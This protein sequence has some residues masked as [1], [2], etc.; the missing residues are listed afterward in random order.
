MPLTDTAIKNAKPTEKP[1]KIS[2]GGG[3][4]IQIQPTGSKLW[5]LKYRFGGVE[6][7]IGLGMYPVISL[8]RAREL[9]DQNKELLTRNIDP[10]TNRKAERLSATSDSQS[11]E[12]VARQW[13][14]L[15]EPR[16][17]KSHSSKII[18]RLERDVFPWI[19]KIPAAEIKVEHIRSVINRV[20]GRGAND[21]A[22]RVRQNI[23]QV[24]KYAIAA[25]KRT[26]PDPTSALSAMMAPVRRGHYPSFTTP[27][28]ARRLLLAMRAFQGSLVVKNALLIAPLVFVRPGE[29]RIAKWKDIDLK[30]RRWDFFIT[31][32]RI[33]HVVPL[34]KQ[35]VAL[36]EELYPLTGRGV[37]VFPGRDPKK[38]M[39]DAAMNASLQRMGF[40]TRKEFT[41]HGVRAMARTLIAEHLGYPKEVI[42][43][44]LAH[45]TIKGSLGSAYD[46]TVFLEAR[47]Q[48]MQDW[49]DY[50]DRLVEE[51][52][53]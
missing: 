30:K 45:T 16:W 1:R 5:F 33:D 28:D 51:P 13:F 44:Q 40:D 26:D 9:R 29:L 25:G 8:K 48:M 21:T 15:H 27:E 2:D 23:G 35:A 42:E 14:L 20:I 11:F 36:L 32:T 53:D 3:L 10:L 38:P 49:A 46:R 34:S 52:L 47:Q 41:M 31:K 6:K 50:L 24:L 17:A 39:S 4:Y 12:V 18:Q 37:W 7:R 19:G 43:P 22:L